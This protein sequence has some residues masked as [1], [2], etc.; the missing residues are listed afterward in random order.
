MKSISWRPRG[1]ATL[2]GKKE[3]YRLSIATMGTDRRDPSKEVLA[4]RVLFSDTA[5][6]AELDNAF[7]AGRTI[8]ATKLTPEFDWEDFNVH[9]PD[10]FPLFT[11][12][13]QGVLTVCTSDQDELPH[14]GQTMVALVTPKKGSLDK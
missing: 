5:T 13:G 12:D 2:F 7:A 11:V 1:G 14:A 3:F 6:Y 4:G 10:S 8:K 9:H